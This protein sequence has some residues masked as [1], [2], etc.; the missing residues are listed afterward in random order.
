M[1]QTN[2]Q[3]PQINA[4]QA[5]CHAERREDGSIDPHQ[6]YMGVISITVFPGK[7]LPN[8]N[9][10][11]NIIIEL[12]TIQPGINYPVR[13]ARFRNGAL[14]EFTSGKRLLTFFNTQGTD[15]QYAD[16]FGRG[17][18]EFLN[19][20]VIE[21]MLSKIESN[22]PNYSRIM[23]TVDT[24]GKAQRL[25]YQGIERDLSESASM[26]LDELSDE[27]TTEVSSE[28]ESLLTGEE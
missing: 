27:N 21:K 20:K 10:L 16:H 5:F 11:A 7:R 24:E 28:N 17:F 1:T 3:Q 2:S 26:I 8:V 12:R 14:K 18:S 19:Q 23:F 15:L 6:P 9:I 4:V 13:I 25:E 22:G